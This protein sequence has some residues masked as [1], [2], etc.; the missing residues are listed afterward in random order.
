MLTYDMGT[1]TPRLSHKAL[2]LLGLLLQSRSHTVL[3]RPTIGMRCFPK[4]SPDPSFLVRVTRIW[5]LLVIVSWCSNS[6][7]CPLGLHG[8]PGGWGTWKG[9]DDVGLRDRMMIIAYEIGP[10]R[11]PCG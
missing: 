9:E 4:R 6:A 8:P 5:R 11:M 10:V 1:E 7:V 2:L 3:E